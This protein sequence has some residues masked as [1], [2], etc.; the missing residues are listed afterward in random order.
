MEKPGINVRTKEHSCTS[1]QECQ[2]RQKRPAS[3][4]D[5]RHICSRSLYDI[6]LTMAGCMTAAE[7]AKTKA[8]SEEVVIRAISRGDLDG[9]LVSGT[10]YVFCV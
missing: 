1:Q 9:H 10:W 5:V 6:S 8:T 2:C 7:Y 3:E 4:L